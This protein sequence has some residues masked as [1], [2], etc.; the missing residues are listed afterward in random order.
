MDPHWQSAHGC[1]CAPLARSSWA[2]APQARRPHGARAPAPAGRPGPASRRLAR[3]V[4]RLRRRPPPLPA[5]ARKNGAACR[6]EPLEKG[7][8]RLGRVA[9]HVEAHHAPRLKGASG[10]LKVA[11]TRRDH[12][13]IGVGYFNTITIRAAG[14]TDGGRS[15]EGQMLCLFQASPVAP[16][17]LDAPLSMRAAYRANTQRART[18]AQ[19]LAPETVPFRRPFRRPFRST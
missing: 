2:W 13:G 1:Q 3:Q 18:Q 10:R 17:V 19:A 15:S 11:A 9:R 5:S 8:P 7:P 4:H 12:D 6:C 14:S 16:G